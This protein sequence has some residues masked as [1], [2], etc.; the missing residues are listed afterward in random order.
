MN[1]EGRE[2]GREAY[3]HKH[4][5]INIPSRASSCSFN[6]LTCTIPRACGMGMGVRV[7]GGREVSV[8]KMHKER[9]TRTHA[10]TLAHTL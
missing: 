7:R 10:H 2:R 9:Y 1:K 4:T 5:C 6:P 8:S 3:T